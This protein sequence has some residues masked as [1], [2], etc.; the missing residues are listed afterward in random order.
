[1]A[2]NYFGKSWFILRRYNEFHNLYEGVK[3][4]HPDVPLKFP[5]KRLFANFDPKFVEKRRNGLDEF[6]G[7]LLNHP[8]TSEE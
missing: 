6:V 1:M 5:G 8:V 3:D 7:M 2:V 4:R